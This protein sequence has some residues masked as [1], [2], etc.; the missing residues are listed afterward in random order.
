MKLVEIAVIL[1][2]V[3]ILAVK[4]DM[5]GIIIGQYLEL[6]GNL[7][8]RLMYL[9]IIADIRTDWIDSEW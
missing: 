8:A 1:I 3:R 2:W 4:V 6:H 5:I 9:P 7:A